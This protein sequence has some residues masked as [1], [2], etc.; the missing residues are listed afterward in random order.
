[1]I[2]QYLYY[3]GVSVY[4]HDLRLDKQIHGSTLDTDKMNHGQSYIDYYRT[5]MRNKDLSALLIMVIELDPANGVTNII[6]N[7]Y[8]ENPLK[9]KIIINTKARENVVAK[10]ESI[11]ASMVWPASITPTASFTEFDG[12]PI[13]IVTS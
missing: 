10:G 2:R 11:L 5:M 13:N 4:S 7:E 12:Q 3:T 1:M 6:M 9:K 8:S